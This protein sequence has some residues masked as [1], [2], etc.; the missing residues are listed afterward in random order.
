MTWPKNTP[1]RTSRMEGSGPETVLWDMV[2]GAIAVGG[3]E[4][5]GVPGTGGLGWRRLAQ[6]ELG[7]NRGLGK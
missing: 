3:Q 2:G 4:P 1:S 6:K 7:V 5:E